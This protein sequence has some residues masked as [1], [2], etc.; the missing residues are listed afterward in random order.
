MSQADSEQYLRDRGWV[1]KSIGVPR[2]KDGLWIGVNAITSR[3]EDAVAIQRG[4]DHL[5]ERTSAYTRKTWDQWRC[6]A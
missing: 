4:Q 5:Q 2:N 1:F 6:K 3:I